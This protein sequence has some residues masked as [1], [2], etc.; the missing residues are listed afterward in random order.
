MNFFIIIL[1]F[2]LTIAFLFSIGRA[3]IKQTDEEQILKKDISF[4]RLQ[5][6][7]LKKQINQVE[8][9]QDSKNNILLSDFDNYRSKV[10]N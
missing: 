2:L 4:L 6:F 3:A 10:K 9:Y 8:E 7:S 1:T 5:I